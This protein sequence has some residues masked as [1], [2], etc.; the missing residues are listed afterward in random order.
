M[1]FLVFLMMIKKKSVIWLLKEKNASGRNERKPSQRVLTLL[2]RRMRKA[3]Q[4]RAL[5][6]RESLSVVS[7][8]T[9]RGGG[10]HVRYEGEAED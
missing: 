7:V 2:F 5:T 1:F 3:M 4:E 10:Q 8:L 6:R 9:C